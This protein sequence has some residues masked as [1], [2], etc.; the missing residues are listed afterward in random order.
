[1]RNL[2]RHADV[3][4]QRGVRVN[5]FAYVYR[6][7]PHLDG[8]CNLAN[9]VTGMRVDHAAAQDQRPQS[10]RSRYSFRS[11]PRTIHG[12]NGYIG[13]FLNGQAQRPH[14]L[15]INSQVHYI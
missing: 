10:F 5:R 11:C 12:L 1:M 7:S 9:H 8:Q 13:P 14:T 6:I 3:F 2:R 4:A 15:E